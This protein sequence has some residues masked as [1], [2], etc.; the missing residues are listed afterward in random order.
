M[1][2]EP[3]LITAEITGDIAL[4]KV[5]NETI[6]LRN[7]KAAQR[8]ILE[9]SGTAK[10]VVLDLSKVEFIDSAGLGTLIS[11]LRH[12]LAKSGDMRLA[13]PTVRVQVLLEVTRLER[14]FSVFDDAASALASFA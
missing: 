8:E 6:D 1:N 12:F 11:T 14:V 3:F 7:A 2:S 9:R 10:H 5:T 4:L 13:G